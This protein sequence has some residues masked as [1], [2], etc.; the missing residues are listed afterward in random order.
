M[1]TEGSEGETPWYAVRSVYV[2]KAGSDDQTRHYEERITIW[3]AASFEVAMERAEAEAV[4]YIEGLDSDYLVD[5]GQAFQLFGAPGDGLRSPH[6][7]DR[8]TTSAAPSRCMPCS[9][10]A[11]RPSD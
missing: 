5:F 2:R 8:S 1:T 4:E 6:C 9:G 3:R 10:N 7:W 11:A